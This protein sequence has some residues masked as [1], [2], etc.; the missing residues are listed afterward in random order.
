[1]AHKIQPIRGTKDIMNLDALLFNHIVDISRTQS[2][3]FNYNEII[4]PI[5]EFSEVFHR[6]LGDT[7]D[8]VSKETY[9]FMDRDKTSITLRPEFTAGVVRAFI[10]N[11]LTQDL[12]QKLFSYGPVFRHERP[13]KAR[14]RQFHQINCEF[15]GAKG[16]LSDAETIDLAY[17]ILKNL[18]LSSIITLEINSIGD[19]ESRNIYKEKLITYLE[20]YKN[21]LSETSLERL[22]KNPLRILDSKDENDKK[23]LSTA[24]IMLESMTDFAKKYFDNL[25]QALTNLNIEYTINPKIVRGLDYYT[26]TVF[27]FTTNQLGSQG[28]V[29]A[30]GRYDGLVELMGGPQVPAIGFAAGIER[31][32]ELLKLQDHKASINNIY[33][34][35][36]IGEKAEQAA[37]KIAHTLRHTGIIC[38]LDFS[39]KVDK[40]FKRANKLSA[41]GAIILGDEEISKN[42]LKYKDLLTGN[43]LETTL[44]ELI[45]QLLEKL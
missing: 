20:K 6:T 24:P 19:I 10:F 21:D 23:I 28:T 32:V 7:S 34:I 36:P 35:I 27:E 1:M 33:S 16:F 25:L 22:Y 17:S 39:S 44:E 45:S 12:P 31:L 30:G 13:Q 40:R 41:K 4:T 43:E 26:H 15:F 29:L 18:N 14:Y 9:T 2:N 3:L 8:I 5:F 11:S 38:D 42:T 37:L